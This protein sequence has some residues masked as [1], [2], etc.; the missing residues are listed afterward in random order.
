MQVLRAYVYS[1]FL[2]F[3]WLRLFKGLRLFWTLKYVKE[4]LLPTIRGQLLELHDQITR[5]QIYFY[6]LD[7]IHEKT[8]TVPTESARV[9]F[10][11]CVHQPRKDFWHRCRWTLI[12][13]SFLSLAAWKLLNS[14]LHTRPRLRA[15]LE[16]LPNAVA[17]KFWRLL[18]LK[19]LQY[20]L[21]TLILKSI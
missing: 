18:F 6:F 16:I 11:C 9:I 19:I 17:I 12:S 13:Q 15:P 21:Q 8:P 2:I 7:Q 3:Q 10:K 5:P 14:I 4:L 20:V 1:F